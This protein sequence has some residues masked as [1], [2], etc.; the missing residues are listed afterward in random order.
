MAKNK[1]ALIRYRALDKCLSNRR[2]RYCFD[3]LMNAVNRA[4][5]DYDPATKGISRSML[6]ED[7]NFLSSSDGWNADIERI[8]EGRHTFYRYADADF[9][10]NKSPLSELE[11]AQL[12][13]A[14]R[15]LQQFKG[16]P[17][18]EWL[19]EVNAKL[20]EGMAAN[21]ENPLIAFDNNQYL[22]GIEHLGDLY[23]AIR[24]QRPLHITYQHFKAPEPYQ[25]LFHPY[26]LKQYNNR[27][28]VFGHCP[29]SEIT[30]HN[31][32]LDRIAA[33]QEANADHVPNTTIDF[34][35]YFEDL[36]GVTRPSDGILQQIKLW[37][38]PDRTGYILTKPLHGSQKKI[39]HD[40]DGLVVSIE[41]IIN[42][43]LL[44]L[45]FSFG[46][47]LKVLAPQSLQERLLK[48]AQDV[49]QRYA[50]LPEEVSTPLTSER[51]TA[52]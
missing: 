16:L 13:E 25:L 34:N 21:P 41:V 52:L 9:S 12:Q 40:A 22:K 28:F 10:I 46:C 24:Y 17:Q 14:V 2:V 36:V 39:S 51:L 7:L 19:E 44:Q 37:I 15:V 49:Q 47:S 29:E 48:E 38:H 32:A 5:E 1:H 33:L 26:F 43:E 27:W 11:L 23:A 6:Y 42:P 18:F 4:L 3:D 45:L 50:A 30:L 35:E 31:L 20:S 8:K